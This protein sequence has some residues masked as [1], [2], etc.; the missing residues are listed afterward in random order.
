MSDQTALSKNADLSG[1]SFFFFFF[2]YVISIY[3]YIKY[4][5]VDKMFYCTSRQVRITTI[6]QHFL[7]KGMLLLVISVSTS[8]L[9]HTRFYYLVPTCN[10]DHF[11]KIKTVNTWYILGQ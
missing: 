6:K 1:F 3:G 8:F 5:N 7:K 9:R 2:L 4:G 11:K 10:K